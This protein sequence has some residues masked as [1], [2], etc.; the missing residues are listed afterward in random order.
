MGSKIYVGG[1]PF[2]TTDDQL[3]AMFTPYGAVESAK[4]IMDKVTGQSRG[5]GFVEMNSASEAQNAIAGLNATQIDG[6]TLTVDLAR[7]GTRGSSS[8][9]GG[10]G[11]RNRRGY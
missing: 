5:F 11:G 6:R 8:F 3:L 10:G 1:L 4:V 7:P 2:S 9:G